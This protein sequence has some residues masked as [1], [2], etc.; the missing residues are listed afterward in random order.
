MQRRQFLKLAS[1]APLLPAFLR[2]PGTSSIEEKTLIVLQFSGGNDGLNTVVPY[3]HDAYH[4]ARPTLAI[5]EREVLRIDK[6]LGLGFHPAF[7][8]LRALME[9]GE[10]CVINS[11]GYPNPD[12]SHFR[13]M[14]IWQTGSG[15]ADYWQTGWL[16]RYLDHH[17][18]GKPNHHALDLDE[19]VSLALRGEIRNGFAFGSTRQLDRTAKNRFHHAAVKRTTA[20][21]HSELHFLYKTLA[22][23]QQSAAYLSEKSR[24]HAARATYPG[25]KFGRDLK[26]I[27]ELM[28]AGTDTRVY[29]AALDGFDTH[30]RQ[31]G[32][33][34]RLL[35]EYAEGVAA[36]VEDLK[37]HRLFD[38]TLILT[39]SE[40]GRRVAENAGGGTDHGT[41]NNVFLMGGGLHRAGFYNDAPNLRN[42]NE[43]DLIHQVDFRSIYTDALGWLGVDATTVLG[44]RFAG[45][46]IV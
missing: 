31:A 27:A 35:K 7:T 6:T 8:P 32:R 21:N 4:R 2:L 23:T 38:D 41:A 24:S 19:G 1:T 16:G 26:Q 33:Q 46:G 34:Q 44:G 18:S 13:S 20:Q 28:T 10:M 15:S 40:F 37:R 9:E 25:G 43:G 11:V 45:L 14:D 17:G 36:L 3:A 12:R 22:D 39:F 29:Y 42:L 5:S 30:T